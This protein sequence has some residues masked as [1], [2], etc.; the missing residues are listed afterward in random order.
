MFAQ[1][2]TCFWI[3]DSTSAFER[4]SSYMLSIL[5]SATSR[6]RCSGPDVAM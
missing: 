2:A 3:S 4:S 1:V 6:P 5:F